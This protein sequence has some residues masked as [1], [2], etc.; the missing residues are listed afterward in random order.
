[1]YVELKTHGGGHDDNGPAWISRVKFSKSGKSIYF[2]GKLLQRYNAGCGNYIDPETEDVY[3][4][5][6]PKKDGTDRYPW[7]REKVFIEE[8]VREEYWESIRD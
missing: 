5:S 7:A 2:H 1:M 4:V 6:G 8:D 3:W